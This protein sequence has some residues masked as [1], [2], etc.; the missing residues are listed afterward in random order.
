MISTMVNGLQGQVTLMGFEA[1]AK[2]KHKNPKHSIYLVD[3]EMSLGQAA[4]R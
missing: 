1:V 3:E 2:N 4:V